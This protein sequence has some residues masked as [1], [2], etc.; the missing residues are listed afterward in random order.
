MKQQAAEFAKKLILSSLLIVGLGCGSSNPAS[1]IAQ[2]G[3][4]LP[5]GPVIVGSGGEQLTVSMSQAVDQ[6]QLNHSEMETIY[7][8]QNIPTTC[9]R[10][11]QRGTR[12]DCHIENEQQCTTQDERVC[13]DVAFPVCQT[14]PRRVCETTQQCTTDTEQVCHGTG[15]Q[16]V[17]TTVPHKTC[18]PVE[19]CQTKNDQV[20]HNETRQE[21]TTIPQRVCTTVPRQE[22]RDVP[23]IVQEQYPCTKPGQVAVGQRLKLHQLAQIAINVKNPGNLNLSSDSLLVT[24]NNGVVG[25]T[26]NSVSGIQYQIQQ[27]SQT[28][29]NAS[30]TEEVINSSFDVNALY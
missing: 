24:L 12:Q 7:E 6:L 27:T 15:A 25:V 1:T 29:S 11:V 26:A 30:A 13:K 16:K 2:P 19:T 10:S 20:C 8:T 17:C 14:I 23:V 9:T 21:C 4:G 3:V 5:G 18:K 22:C 28:V